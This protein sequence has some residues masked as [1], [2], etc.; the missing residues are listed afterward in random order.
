M[1]ELCVRSARRP[2][3]CPRP[4]ASSPHPAP[5]AALDLAAE[6]EDGLADADPGAWR[7]RTL[8]D[9]AA[10]GGCG[11][12][13]SRKADEQRYSAASIIF[14]MFRT[15]SVWKQSRMCVRPLNPLTLSST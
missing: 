3:T 9:V 7:G 10:A 5:A 1:T 14:S 2:R 6:V 15:T 12:R 13:L 4:T 11:W 8:D